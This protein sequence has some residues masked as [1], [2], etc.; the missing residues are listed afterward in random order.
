MDGPVDG[1]PVAP[2][3]GPPD[4]S[5]DGSPDGSLDGSPD[6]SPDGTTVG[7]PEGSG[8]GSC[9]PPPGVGQ[10]SPAGRDRTRATARPVS[11]VTCSATAGE[12]T[13]AMTTNS[14]STSSTPMYSMVVAPAEARSPLSP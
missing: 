11:H 1:D 7:A 5:L 13:T 12:A 6:G 4:G 9:V 2:P 3:D 14:A 10:S 8:S